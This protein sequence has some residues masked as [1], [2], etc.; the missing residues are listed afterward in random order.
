[1]RHTWTEAW[2]ISTALGE[3]VLSLSVVPVGL[4]KYNLG[5]PVRPLTR[6][7]AR[8]AIEQVD[9]FRE[10]RCGTE[11]SGGVTRRMSFI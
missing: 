3:G 6:D 11:V 2:R 4:T 10:R 8:V 1:M 9:R 7:E 5:R